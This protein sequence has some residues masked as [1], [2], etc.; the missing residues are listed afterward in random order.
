[1]STL[2]AEVTE[3]SAPIAGHERTGALVSLSIGGE[4]GAGE[5]TLLPGYSPDDPNGLRAE[6]DRALAS[7]RFRAAVA[8]ADPSRIDAALARVRR[9]SPGAA[10]ALETAALDLAG[11]CLGRPVAELLAT[12]AAPRPVPI[13]A[14]VPR[15]MTVDD[16]WRAAE[17]AW[18]SGIRTLKLKVGADGSTLALATRLRGAFGAELDLRF[19]AN[20][21]WTLST[22]VDELTSLASVMPSFCE[23][24]VAPDEF[25][26]LPFG[27]LPVAIAAD[28]TVWKGDGLAE[29]LSLVR[30][31]TSDYVRGATTVPPPDEGGGLALPLAAIVVKP[32]LVGGLFPARRIARLAARRGIP[33]V[34]THVFDGPIAMAACAELA[35]VL[36]PAPLACGLAAHE[37]LSPWGETPP[38]IGAATAGSAGRPG[39]GVP[40]PEPPR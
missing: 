38:Q 11:R 9:N 34:L 29:V 40:L 37:G 19:D 28:E 36:D 30:G 17:A 33:V 4:R 27:V 12:S 22:V 31:A 25:A 23:Q 18:E 35:S 6:I 20:G 39:L 13:N 24:P 15:E 32:A 7:P 14:V 16:A 10:F 26:A 2:D 5:I 8:D 1:M 21:A 3:W